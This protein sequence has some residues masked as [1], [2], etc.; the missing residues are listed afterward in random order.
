VGQ[1]SGAV[2]AITCWADPGASM[3]SSASGAAPFALIRGQRLKRW[4]STMLQLPMRVQKVMLAIAASTHAFS[5]LLT[6]SQV[7]S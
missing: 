2:Q 3:P 5:M 6:I 4:Q 1:S 7:E